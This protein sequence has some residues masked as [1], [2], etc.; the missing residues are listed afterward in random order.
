MKKNPSADSTERSAVAFPIPY[1]YSFCLLFMK[2]WI[3]KSPFVAADGMHEIGLEWHFP[4]PFNC[5]NNERGGH[6]A[7][8]KMIIQ[9][10]VSQH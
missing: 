4:S 2:Q 10:V 8:E 9:F 7:V 1:D 6:H 3:N 5:T